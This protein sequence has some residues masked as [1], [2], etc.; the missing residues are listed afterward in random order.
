MLGDGSCGWERLGVV[1]IDWVRL[2]EVRECM[3]LVEE[4]WGYMRLSV[5]G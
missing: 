3:M 1:G 2:E 4:G 5:V